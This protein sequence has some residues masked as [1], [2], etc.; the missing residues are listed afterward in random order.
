MVEEKSYIQNIMCKFVKMKVQ[1]LFIFIASALS[2]DTIDF[3]LTEQ[4][5]SNQNPCVKGFPGNDDEVMFSIEM[6]RLK[7]AKHQH[8]R[9][10]CSRICSYYLAAVDIQTISLPHPNFD[11]LNFKMNVRIFSLSSKNSGRT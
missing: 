4:L 9:Y 6:M 1:L 10:V 7:Y 11:W 5:T 2:S 8:T 3:I